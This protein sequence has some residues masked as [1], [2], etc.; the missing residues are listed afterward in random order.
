MMQRTILLAVAL[1]AGCGETGPLAELFRSD[2]PYEEYLHTLQGA[3]ITRTAMGRDWEQAGARALAQPLVARLPFHE[4]GYFAPHTPAAVVYRFELK[5]GRT[6]RIEVRFESEQ[7]GRLFVDLFRMAEDDSARRVASL[8][9]DTTLTQ[10]EVRRD[11][12]YLLRLQPELLRGGRYTL[13]ERTE[14]TLQF[15]LPQLNT[16]AVRS[17]FGVPRDAG[18]RTHQGVDIFAPRGTPVVAVAD[19]TAQPSTNELGGNVVWLHD[20]KRGRTYYYAHLERWALGES[21]SVNAGDT[22]GFV[23]NTGNARTTPPHLHFGIYDGGP[24]DPL[25]FLEPDDPMP[26]RL[27]APA[28]QVGEWVRVLPRDIE[29]RNGAHRS[30]TA[31]ARLPRGWVAQVSGASERAFR[32]RLPDDSEG[33][34]DA[35][36]VVRASRPLGAQELPAGTILRE[37]PGERSPAMEVLTAGTRGDL[38]GRFGDFALV[39]LPDARLGWVSEVRR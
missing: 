33:Y 7:P 28:D 13:E 32:V 1:L 6:L 10:Y 11:G 24:V 38:L 36:A 34:L 5:R 3:G 29:L 30:A 39:R 20:G 22:L 35:A 21:G 25:P 31:L 15:P 4:T 27:T 9:Q 18:R 12:S 26:A 16:Q 2:S 14:A 8:P 19:G 23:G 37:S 17:R